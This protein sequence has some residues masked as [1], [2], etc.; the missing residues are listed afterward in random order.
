MPYKQDFSFFRGEDVDVEVTLAG[1][2]DITGVAL[3]F[4]LRTAAEAASALLTRTTANGGISFTAEEGESGVFHVLIPEAQ[5]LLI[6]VASYTYNLWRIDSGILKV[7]AY[8]TCQVLGQTKNNPL[9]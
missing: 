9:P 6:P 4:Y 1:N 8:G 3:G 7:L 5:T 2:P